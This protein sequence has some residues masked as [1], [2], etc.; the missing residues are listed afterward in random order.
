MPMSKPVLDQI[1]DAIRTSDKL[2]IRIA[3][4]LGISRSTLSRLMSGERAVKVELLERLADCVGYR[5]VVEP[6]TKR[7]GR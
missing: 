2:P 5:I 4:E 6:K 3:E 1:R 7:K